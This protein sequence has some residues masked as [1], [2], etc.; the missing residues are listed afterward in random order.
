M[1][2]GGVLNTA[3]KIAATLKQFTAI[4]QPFLSK[5]SFILRVMF[6]CAYFLRHGI[7]IITGHNSVFFNS[8]THPL[9]N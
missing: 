7:K 5:A 1:V 6:M 8:P 2:D 4:K 9:F 3:K